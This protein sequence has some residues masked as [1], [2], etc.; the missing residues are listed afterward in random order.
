MHCR[1]EI[2][3]LDASRK[4]LVYD[5]YSKLIRATDTIRS[6]RTLYIEFA[7]GGAC[8]YFP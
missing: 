3:A 8:L 7:L 2:R 6:V 4:A 5:N 1:A